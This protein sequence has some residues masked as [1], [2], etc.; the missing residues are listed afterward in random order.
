MKI[1]QFLCFVILMVGC[2]SDDGGSSAVADKP[3]VEIKTHRIQTEAMDFEGLIRPND[4]ILFVGDEI[5]Q[6]MYYT[7]AT[8]AGLLA[9]YP[10]HGLTFYN[11]GRDGATVKDVDGWIDELLLVSKPSIVFVCLGRND[12]EQYWPKPGESD[13]KLN[14]IVGDYEKRMRLLISRINST[15]FVRRVIVLSSPAQPVLPGADGRARLYNRTLRELAL[16]GQR[17]AAAEGEGFIDLFE[18]MHITNQACYHAGSKAMTIGYNL[19]DESAHTVMASVI[20]WG[21]GIDEKSFGELGWAPL[22]ARKMITIRNVLG[23]NLPTPKSELAELSREVYRGLMVPD[24]RFFRL[25]RISVPLS[26]KN[27]LPASV[28]SPEVLQKLLRGDWQRIHTLTSYYVEF[29]KAKDK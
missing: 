29:E 21:L 24:Q 4:R 11:G 26:L 25:W 5:T 1:F 18:P 19:P 2:V 27:D 9:K 20:F 22:A 23:M 10:E 3:A 16:A 15:S 6:Q 8:A 28:K 7:R 13:E 17:A 12:G 14:R